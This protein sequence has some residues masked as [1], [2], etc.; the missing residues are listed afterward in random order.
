MLGGGEV[1]PWGGHIAMLDRS[2]LWTRRDGGAVDLDIFKRKS[3][4]GVA[5]QFVR[6]SGPVTYE[7]KISSSLSYLALHDFYRI[8]GETRVDSLPPSRSQDLR[9][10]LAVVPADCT[11]EGWT[12]IEKPASINI[13]LLDDLPSCRRQIDLKQLLP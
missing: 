10:K 4:P 13:L 9:G 1:K 3:W 5:A 12:Q 8:D 11:C 6:I 7:F 2:V